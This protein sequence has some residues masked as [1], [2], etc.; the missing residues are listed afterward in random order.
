MHKDTGI[1][2][3]GVMDLI[4]VSQY[5]DTL[6]EVSKNKNARAVFIQQDE[7]SAGELQDDIRLSMLQGNIKT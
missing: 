7:G 1:D 4:L 2:S 6:K 5:F 3:R